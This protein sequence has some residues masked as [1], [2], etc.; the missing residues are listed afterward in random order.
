MPPSE[1]LPGMYA[2]VLGVSECP[3]PIPEL[4]L[5][6]FNEP[7]A[8][9]LAT[10]KHACWEVCART[11][12]R[13]WPK[14]CNSRLRRLPHTLRCCPKAPTLALAS[15]T[16]CPLI[17]LICYLWFVCPCLRPRSF[18]LLSW[19]SHAFASP[20]LPSAEAKRPS[21]HSGSLV[22]PSQANSLIDRSLLLG[23]MRLIESLAA[24]ILSSLLGLTAVQKVAVGDCTVLQICVS[25]S[26]QMSKLELQC[27]MRVPP[28]LHQ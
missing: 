5:V 13:L 10:R 21:G 18:A 14:A 19:G 26:T 7:H 12:Q 27:L 3:R 28:G 16:S 25:S 17:P 1:L 8:P 22:H 23:L 2:E 4:R 6:L 24:E 9:A 15:T 20:F 11:P